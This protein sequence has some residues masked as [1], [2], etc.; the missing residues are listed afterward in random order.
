MIPAT[1]KKMDTTGV[2]ALMNNLGR[3][4]N[5]LENIAG[6]GDTEGDRVRRSLLIIEGKGNKR[7]NQHQRR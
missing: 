3:V 4:I 1:I 2:A 6:F 5:H 7:N